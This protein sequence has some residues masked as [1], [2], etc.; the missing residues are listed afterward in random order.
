MK[1]IIIASANEG[2]ISEIK[3]IF[4][5]IRLRVISLSELNDVPEI[6][7]SG[8]SFEANA[9]IKARII[10]EKF[11]IPVIGD[12]SGLVVEQLN[13]RPGV[14]SSRYAGE[15]ATDELNNLKLVSELLSFPEPH[16]AKFVCTAFFYDGQKE[17]I[18]KGE[19]KGRIIKTPRGTN[20]FGYDPLFIPDGFG[21]TL[22]ELPADVKNKISHRAK[23][24][25]EMK[26][27]LKRLRRI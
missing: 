1:E 23:A 8:D 6:I 11:R 16:K 7:E 26:T 18:T 3:N 5:D 27:M 20:G 21:K 2:K 9:E 19:V 10:F 24:F 4:S 13:G 17:I 12:D 14:F 15:N 25:E 22:A